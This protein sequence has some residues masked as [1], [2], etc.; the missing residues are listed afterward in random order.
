MEIYKNLSFELKSIVGDYLYGDKLFF[1][2][3]RCVIGL[4]Y[5]IIN[6]FVSKCTAPIA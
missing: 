5:L 3:I 1:K 6:R 2:H 4:L